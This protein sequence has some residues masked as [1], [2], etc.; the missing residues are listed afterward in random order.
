MLA[1]AR[2]GEGLGI[3]ILGATFAWV[4]GSGPASRVFNSVRKVPSKSWPWVKFL[5]GMAFGGCL[6]CAVAVVSN[7][8]PFL[9]T[10][11]VAVFGM[12][13]APVGQFA[14][15]KPWL[16]FI[17][18]LLG[19]A[20]FVAATL[21]LVAALCAAQLLPNDAAERLG[22]LMVYALIAL[23]LGRWWLVKGW[24]L[25]LAGINVD[26][27]GPT[28]GPAVKGESTVRSYIF[29]LVGAIILTLWLGVLAFSA[30][31]DSTF[32]FEVKPTTAPPSPLSPVIALM[33]LAWWPYSCWKSILEREPNTNARTLKRHKAVTGIVG[34]LFMTALCI[35]IAFGIQSGNDRRSTAQIESA[36]KGFQDVATKIGAIKSRDLQTTQDYIDAYEA[37]DPLLGDF[38]VKLRQLTDALSEAEQRDRSSGPLNIQRLYG[39]KSKEW[40]AWDASTLA[41]LREDSELT[42]KQIQVVR[43]MA[44][45]PERPQVEYWEQDFQPLQR[46]EEVLGQKIAAAQKSKPK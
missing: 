1:G 41:L 17:V 33:L 38:D 39:R 22:E 45:L 42:K 6:M 3:F 15:Q 25:T 13:T 30:F 4:F 26:P 29:L 31:S 27:S 36:T 28:E 23:L 2:L 18:S 11:S 40:L 19:I 7:F 20:V 46:E 35:A 12:L 37:I 10:A 32:A 16:K 43:H 34:G 44:E 8:N 5:L 14:T 24:R 9:V 21:G